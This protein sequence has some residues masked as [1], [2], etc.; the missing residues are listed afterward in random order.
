MA[1]VSV[2]SGGSTEAGRGCT[3][4]SA[5][6]LP[7][8][9]PRES[10]KGLAPD[11]GPSRAIVAPLVSSASRSANDEL[12]WGREGGSARPNLGL[13]DGMIHQAVWGPSRD[14]CCHLSERLR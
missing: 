11:A 9:S 14:Q 6:Q 4:G 7:G 10:R 12:T 8:S 3:G 1:A 13:R 5:Q 2:D